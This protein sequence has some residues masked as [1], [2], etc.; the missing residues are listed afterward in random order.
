[1]RRI[2]K[3]A[4]IVLLF[5]TGACIAA[6]VPEEPW[7]LLSYAFFHGGFIH[8]GFNSLFLFFIGP[9]LEERLGM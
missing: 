6:R 4:S 9:H 2:L 7:R 3:G 5:M 8:I 1:M